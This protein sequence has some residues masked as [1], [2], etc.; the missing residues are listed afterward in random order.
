MTKKFK[1]GDIIQCKG[2][3]FAEREI[4]IDPTNNSCK[5]LTRFLEDDSVVES[6]AKIIDDNYWL[7]GKEKRRITK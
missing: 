4:V 3:H 7:K 2:E 5:Y 1:V 6:D